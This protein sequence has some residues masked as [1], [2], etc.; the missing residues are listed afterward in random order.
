MVD[1]MS[2]AYAYDFV[3][4]TLFIALFRLT[5]SDNKTRALLNGRKDNCL[6]DMCSTL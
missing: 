6:T 2:S 1:N 5:C 3:L 4:R